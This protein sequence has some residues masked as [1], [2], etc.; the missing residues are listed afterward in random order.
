MTIVCES[1]FETFEVY[2]VEGMQMLEVAGLQ[3]ALESVCSKECGSGPNVFKEDF[4]K[5]QGLYTAPS[6]YCENWSLFIS[7]PFSTVGTNKVLEINCKAAFINKCAGGNHASLQ[8]LFGMLDLPSPVSTNIYSQHVK[9]ICEQSALQA[10]V[11]MK[12]AR[13]EVY[14]YYGASNDDDIVN[15]LVS[16]DGTWQRH[17][18]SSLSGAV[19]ITAHETGKVVD[20][21]VKSKHCASCKYWEK[22][23][24]TTDAYKMWKETHESEINF[25]GSAGAMEPQGTLEMFQ[26]SLGCKVHYTKLIS[27]GDSKTHSILPKEQPYGSDHPVEKVHCIG[28]VQKHMGTVLCNLK[29]QYK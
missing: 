9:V 26:L 17:G 19:F 4:L 14:Q 13:E 24:K 20:Y 28:H 27:D 10:Q 29:Q 5:K 12:Q 18:F 7:I 16:C 8:M 22:Q 11:S 1:D 21:I 6:L 23:D 3:T 2:E 15:V 25:I